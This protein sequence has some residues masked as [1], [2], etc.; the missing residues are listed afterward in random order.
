MGH[1][2]GLAVPCFLQN[3]WIWEVWAATLMVVLL[4]MKWN[5]FN[6]PFKAAQRLR[7]VNSSR[8]LEEWIGHK[9]SLVPTAHWGYE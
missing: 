1:F 9:A 4:S 8:V 5:V 3:V 2:C 6:V 7:R